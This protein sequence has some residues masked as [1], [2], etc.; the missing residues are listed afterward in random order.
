MVSYLNISA[1]TWFKIAAA[2]FYLKKKNYRFPPSLFTPFKHLFAPTSES[3][4]KNIG[5][6]WSQ[7]WTVFLIKGVNMPCKK[8]LIFNEFCF[9]SRIFLV[10]VL[11]SALVKRWFVS[12]MRD[13][14]FNKKK[15]GIGATI[16]ISQEI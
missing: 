13:F 16:R 1:Q 14:F 11:L 10:L 6:K 8:N 15:K 4:G 2:I 7:V 5:K 9:T 12:H 3:L